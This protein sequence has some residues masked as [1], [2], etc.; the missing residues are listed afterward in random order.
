MQIHASLYESG[1]IHLHVQLY[2]VEMRELYLFMSLSIEIIDKNV[3]FEANGFSELEY[4]LCENENCLK[5]RFE[6]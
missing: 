3:L 2:I 1:N 6:K 4:C 5:V